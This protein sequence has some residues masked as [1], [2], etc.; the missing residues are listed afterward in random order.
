MLYCLA[1]CGNQLF[2]FY[3]NSTDWLSHDVG[4]GCGESW[5]RLLTA[6][7]LFIFC[8]L[9]LCFC[10]ANSRVFFE[11]VSF[12]NLLI[13]FN[14]CFNLYIGNFL[15]ELHFI[16]IAFILLLIVLLCFWSYS[17]RYSF[18]TFCLMHS[19]KKVFEQT[20]I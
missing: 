11:Y 1:F 18:Y 10:V 9:V 8:L 12:I 3:R 20:E 5:N 14:R 16:F 13:N 19:L 2:E 7:Y 6:L 4:S 15:I 17:G